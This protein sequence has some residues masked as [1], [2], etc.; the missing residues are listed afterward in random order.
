MLHCE[1][2]NKVFFNYK[3]VRYG[4]ANIEFDVRDT[5]K[6]NKI[7]I[8]FK[9]KDTDIVDFKEEA[10]VCPICNGDGILYRLHEGL[11]LEDCPELRNI[12]YFHSLAGNEGYIDLICLTSKD[13]LKMN[14]LLQ[15]LENV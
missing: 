7:D 10:G 13:L 8:T 9:L 15:F 11:T 6:S 3:V 14:K 2:C 1:K 4:L 12:K 5:V